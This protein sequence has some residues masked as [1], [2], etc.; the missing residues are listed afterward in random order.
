MKIKIHKT[1]TGHALKIIEG[2]VISHIEISKEIHDVIKQLVYE[3]KELRAAVKGASEEEC[4]MGEKEV[5]FCRIRN[6]EGNACIHCIAPDLI[7]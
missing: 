5:K 3:N 4:I 6:N 1:T 2:D 7:N